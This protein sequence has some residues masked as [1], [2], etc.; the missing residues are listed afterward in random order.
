MA[1]ITSFPKDLIGACVR[2]L[3]QRSLDVYVSAFIEIGNTDDCGREIVISQK[4]L[5]E[6]QVQ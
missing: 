6:H 5:N 3:I 2:V 1:R 4:Q